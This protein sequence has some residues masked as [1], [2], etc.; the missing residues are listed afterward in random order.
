MK[1][2]RPYLISLTVSNLFIKSDTSCSSAILKGKFV[3]LNYALFKQ[4]V[5]KLAGMFVSAKLQLIAESPKATEAYK[6]H[7]EKIN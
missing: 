1:R 6:G 3:F 2:A 7:V 5:N 4:E